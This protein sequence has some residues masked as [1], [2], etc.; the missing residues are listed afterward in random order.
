MATRS[1]KLLPCPSH[2]DAIDEPGETVNLAITGATGGATLG[3]PN[4][5]V[6]TIDDNDG[7]PAFSINDV[8]LAEGNSGTTAFTFTVTKT[9]TTAL[10]SSVNFATADG[11]ATIVGSDYASNS[12]TLNFSASDTSLTITVNVNGDTAVE[13]NETFFVNLSNPTNA[14]ISDSQG[15]GTIDN[16]DTDVTVAVAPSAVAE[17]GATNLVYTFTRS[18]VTTGPLT[19]N[20]SVGGDAIFNTDY[21]QTGATSFNVSSGSVTI[22]ATNAT[23]TVTVDPPQTRQSRGTR[24]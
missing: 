9:G 14:T 2:N 19:V 24:L 16:D 4:T 13:A 17:D 5:A 6:L 1:A 10:A 12:N 3:T 11:T 18:G 20:F 21:T 15:T 7:P 8:T 22:A 23:R